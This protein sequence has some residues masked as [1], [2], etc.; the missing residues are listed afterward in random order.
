[1]NN[2]NSNLL[3]QNIINNAVDGIIV[4]DRKGTIKLINPS[5]CRMFGY[6]E[7]ELLNNNIILLVQSSIYEDKPNNFSPKY[8]EKGLENIIGFGCELTGRRKDGNTFKFNLIINEIELEKGKK[9]FA[10]TIQDITAQ[11][12]IQL[13]IELLNNM[14]EARIS[15]RTNQLAKVVNRLLQTNVALR[16][17][18]S[19]R[20]NIED[21]LVKSKEETLIALESQKIL[22]DLKSRFITTAS[23]E[24]RTPLSCILS[25]AK[26]IGR[27]TENEGQENRVKHIKRIESAVNNLNNLLND[28]LTWSKFEEN[29]IINVPMFFSLEEL[30]HEVI[31]DILIIS[32]KGQNI[33]HNHEGSL[34]NVKLDPIF[35][36]NILLNLLSNAVKY[37]DE[38]KSIYIGT[39]IENNIL[40]I[41]VKDEGV[42]IPS[43]DQ[44]FIFERF[45]RAKNVDNI[46][47]TG[48]GLNIVKKYIELLKGNISFESSTDIGTVFIVTIPLID[49]VSS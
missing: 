34:K 1:M 5:A 25:S 46:Q 40:R 19:Q 42:G 26:L 35:I 10:G 20:K 45:F 3:P 31:E 32:K 48:L 30:I 37:S 24:F 8:I 38:Y 11:K 39:S 43:E 18:I 21:A 22:S 29:K 23:H 28:L 44:V 17:E 36:K 6:S 13:K 33:Y 4:I 27:Y 2:L 15:E 47:G 14:L 41:V 9:L 12:K 16:T 7:V 49:A